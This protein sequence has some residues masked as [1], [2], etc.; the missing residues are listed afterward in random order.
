MVVLLRREPRTRGRVRGVHAEPEH[1][2][3]RA[4]Q[5]LDVVDHGSAVPMILTALGVMLAA[6]AGFS[7]L[8]SP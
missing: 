1:V 8:F 4:V 3:E 5:L 6:A 2:L 7:Q